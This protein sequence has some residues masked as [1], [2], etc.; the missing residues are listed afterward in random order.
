MAAPTA[1]ATAKFSGRCTRPRPSS[2]SGSRIDPPPT[3]TTGG[4]ADDVRLRSTTSA[5]RIAMVSSARR[6]SCGERCATHAGS[7]TSTM[8]AATATSVVV[9]VSPP[10]T[11]A[12]RRSS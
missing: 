4:G 7:P 8:P 2:D 6:T 12:R 9:R 10:N 5:T 11:S 1:L 3:A